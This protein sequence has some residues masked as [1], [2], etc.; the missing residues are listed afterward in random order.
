[1]Y[2]YWAV[3]KRMMMMIVCVVWLGLVKPLLHYHHCCCFIRCHRHRFAQRFLQAE[4]VFAHRTSLEMEMK[5]EIYIYF[6]CFI[7]FRF[8]SFVMFVRIRLRK[9][10]IHSCSEPISA[11]ISLSVALC[12]SQCPASDTRTVCASMCVRACMCALYQQIIYRANI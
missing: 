2:G 9:A 12:R 5:M 8:I 6:V 11:F 1:M 10:K 3:E 4:H 7:S